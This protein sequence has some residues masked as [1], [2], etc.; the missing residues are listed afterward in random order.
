L[1]MDNPLDLNDIT[2]EKAEEL[3]NY[4]KITPQY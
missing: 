3:Y 4:R 2:K 1:K